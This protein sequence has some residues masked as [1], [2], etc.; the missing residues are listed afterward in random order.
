MWVGT[1]LSETFH[2]GDL[3]GYVTS[4]VYPHLAGIRAKI[5]GNIK[6]SQ[7]EKMLENSDQVPDFEE[8]VNEDER[9]NPTPTR[10]PSGSVKA[11]KAPP[12]ASGKPKKGDEPEEPR[13]PVELPLVSSPPVMTEVETEIVNK[14]NFDRSG[15]DMVLHF[16][17]DDEEIFC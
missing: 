13:P 2:L 6:I 9:E 14:L 1:Y 7:R 15:L 8:P 11:N 16:D 12:K 4:T 3:K 5:Q 17:V 10:P